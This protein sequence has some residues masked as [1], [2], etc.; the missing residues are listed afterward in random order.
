MRTGNVVIANHGQPHLRPLGSEWLEVY[1][2]GTW[3]ETQLV[4]KLPFGQRSYSNQP[5]HAHQSPI[6]VRMDQTNLVALGL[7]SAAVD[8]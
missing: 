6:L 8:Q 4:S 3:A 5:S 2:E 7:V 1:P